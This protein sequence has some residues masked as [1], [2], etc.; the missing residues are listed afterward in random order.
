MKRIFATVVMVVLAAIFVATP[1]LAVSS[2]N[3]EAAKKTPTVISM[4]AT[5]KQDNVD[6]RTDTGQIY[7]AIQMTN[8]AFIQYRGQQD[9]VRITASTVCLEWVNKKKSVQIDCSEL[10]FDDRISVNA[11]IDPN[12]KVITAKKVWLKQP[13]VPTP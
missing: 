9:W 5:I 7:V 6:E 1:V 8:R 11:R 10:D 3:I 12:T 2:R 13:R 4:T